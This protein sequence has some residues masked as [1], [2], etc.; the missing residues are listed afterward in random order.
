MDTFNVI[1]SNIC[2]KLR[3]EGA[4]SALSD[5]EKTLQL[6]SDNERAKYLRRWRK[7]HLQNEPVLETILKT[8][9]SRLED[10]FKH[11]G[12]LSEFHDQQK[13]YYYFEAAGFL[14]GLALIYVG[15]QNEVQNNVSVGVNYKFQRVV[16]TGAY[17]VLL[18]LIVIFSSAAAILSKLGYLSKKRN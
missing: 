6:T 18:G 7:K 13:K 16:M 10:Y 3:K 14:F 1:S 15:I 8:E 9:I 2:S 4:V 11:H 5:Y 12:L 17:Q